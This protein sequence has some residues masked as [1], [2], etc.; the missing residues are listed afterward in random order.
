[1]GEFEY[2]STQLEIEAWAQLDN[3]IL[4]WGST[5]IHNGDSPGFTIGI[6]QDPQWGSTNIIRARSTVKAN[7][8]NGFE[9]FLVIMEINPLFC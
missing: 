4:R 6:H 3:M 9:G 7:P 8:K 2:N 5:R 1:M